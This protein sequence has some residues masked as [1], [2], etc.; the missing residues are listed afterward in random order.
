MKAKAL[1]LLSCLIV[2]GLVFLPLVTVFSFAKCGFV[3]GPIWVS[4][5]GGFLGFVNGTSGV[6]QF[7]RDIT[8]YLK[9]DDLSVDSSTQTFLRVPGF[10]SGYGRL[11]LF[12]PFALLVS[13]LF[14]SQTIFIFKCR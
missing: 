3:K 11:F 12:H 7:F 5:A 6:K 14:V 13:S 10:R 1:V 2:I 8:F 4:V 9:T